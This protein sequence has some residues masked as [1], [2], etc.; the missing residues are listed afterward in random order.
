MV[1]ILE[2]WFSK[3]YDLLFGTKVRSGNGALFGARDGFCQLLDSS[4]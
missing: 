1:L 4:R 3:V 2:E